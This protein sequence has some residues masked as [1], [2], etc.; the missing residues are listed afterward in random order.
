MFQQPEAPLFKEQP[1]VARAWDAVD[2]EQAASSTDGVAE[3]QLALVEPGEPRRSPW[4]AHV[5]QRPRVA[6]LVGDKL[7]VHQAAVEG[8]AVER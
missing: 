3:E 1:V 2:D 6:R 4:C 5:G 7:V 8:N